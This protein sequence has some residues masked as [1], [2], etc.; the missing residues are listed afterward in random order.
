M[1]RIIKDLDDEIAFAVGLT[2]G[3]VVLGEALVLL[4]WGIDPREWKNRKEIGHQIIAQR[5]NYV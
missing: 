5:R 4:S 2:F 3:G 1:G